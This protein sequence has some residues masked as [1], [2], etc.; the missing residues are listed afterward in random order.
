M[1]RTAR[2]LFA[3]GI[4]LALCGLASLLYLAFLAHLPGQP[5]TASAHLIELDVP[6]SVHSARYITPAEAWVAERMPLIG[7]AI[8]FVAVIV[9]RIG[10]ARRRRQRVGERSA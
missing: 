4:A 8:G 10:D 2:L 9:R 3:L 6:G 1:H 7:I 5:E